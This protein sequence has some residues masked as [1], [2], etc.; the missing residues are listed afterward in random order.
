[1]RVVEGEEGRDTGAGRAVGCREGLGGEGATG[2]VSL[3]GE[4]PTGAVG[5]GREGATLGGEGSTDTMGCE[6]R[7]D[8]MDVCSRLA[9]GLGPWT[10]IL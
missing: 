7:E 5:C 8:S 1:M 6:E 2:A 3:G 4:G 10:V 9:P